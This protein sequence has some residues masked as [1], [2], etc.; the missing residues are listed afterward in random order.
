MIKNIHGRMNPGRFIYIYLFYTPAEKGNIGPKATYFI[1]Y[2]T[3]FNLSKK[4][5]YNYKGKKYKHER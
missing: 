2:V 3:S 1:D 5:G 4:G